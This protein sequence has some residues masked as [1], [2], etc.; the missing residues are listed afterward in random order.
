MFEKSIPRVVLAAAG[1]PLLLFVAFLAYSHPGYLTNQTYLG[2]FIALELLA[3]ALWRFRQVFFALLMYAFLSA[4]SGLPGGSFGTK[5]RWIFLAVG[6]LVGT[7]I[8]LKERRFRLGFFHLVAFSCVLVGLA[9]SAVSRYPDL[10]MLKALSLFLLFL[11]AGSGAR[12]AVEG[13]ENAFL[14]G[15]VTGCEILVGGT[16]A[17]YAVG[18][19]VMGNPNSLGAVMGV[20]GIPVLLWGILV[21]KELSTDASVRRRRVLLFFLC[22]YL[23]YYS[24]ARAG[25]LA[26]LISSALLCLGLREYKMLVKGLGIALIMFA[27]A[28]ILRPQTVST[29]LSVFTSDVV[30]KGHDQA[31]WASRQSPWNDAIDAI[32]SHFWFGTGFGTTDNPHDSTITNSAFSSN[33]AV[34]AEYGSSYLEIVAWLGITGS[35]PFL[36]LLLLVVEKVVRTFRWMRVTGSAL[37][38][39]VPLALI[40]VAGLVHAAFEDW[41]F[42]VGY[43]LCVFFWSMAFVLVDLAPAASRVSAY[44]LF[45]RLKNLPDNPALPVPGRG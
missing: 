5:G 26:A 7:L 39:A 43:Y 27:A 15:L 11:Y 37:H 30:Y 44:S 18:V 3:L 23:V 2:G 32:N 41:L 35:L 8:A 29:S 42:A 19:E 17:F 16:A 13:R 34:T 4:G 24:H 12:L 9:S 45:P 14:N 1:I 6:A 28:A 38:P 40:V 21:S 22:L 36:F 31:V 25:I 20:A 33:F 10:A